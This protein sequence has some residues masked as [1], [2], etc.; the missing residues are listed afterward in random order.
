MRRHLFASVSAIAVASA[1]ALAMPH[2][3]RAGVTCTGDAC[4]DTISVSLGWTNTDL[5]AVALNLPK[6][7][8]NLGTLNS[9]SIVGTT[10]LYSTGTISNNGATPLSVYAN[11]AST[12]SFSSTGVSSFD[13]FLSSFAGSHNKL[14]STYSSAGLA[15]GHSVAYSPVPGSSQSN[16]VS[17]TNSVT[18]ADLT[19]YESY[20]TAYLTP[21]VTTVT[22]TGSGQVGS[23][24]NASVTQSIAT[25]ADMALTVTYDYTRTETVPEPSSLALIGGA[26]A[27]IGA[28]RRRRRS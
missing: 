20:T 8:A 7:N 11:V 27:G 17:L 25:K 10:E 15:G 1:V 4:V 13:T 26:L 6:F 23:G 28:I 5:R 16:P 9:V 12:W 24:G 19:D 22:R 21:D 3:A 18:P 14:S 2:A